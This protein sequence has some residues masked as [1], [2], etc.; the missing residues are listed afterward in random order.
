MLES[1]VDSLQRVPLQEGK[2]SGQDII[3]HNKHNVQAIIALDAGSNLHLLLTPTKEKESKL[4]TIKLKG[5]SINEVEWIVTGREN[6]VYIDISCKTG[7]LLGFKRPFL[8]FAEDV[9]L[10]ISENE[11]LPSESIYKTCLRWKKFWSPNT[12]KMVTSEWIH[13]IF[14]ELIFLIE[15]LERFGVNTIKSWTG[16]LGRDH[17]FQSS[18]D[19]A[20]EI[21]TSLSIPFKIN[22]NLKQLDTSLFKQLYII[23]YHI[24]ELD[25]GSTLPDLIRHIERLIGDNEIILE[26]FYELLMSSG[27]ELQLESL[28]NEHKFLYSPGAVYLVDNNFPKIVETSFVNPPDHRI[29]GIRYTVELTGIKEESIDSVT[30]ELMILGR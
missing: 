9:L 5:L 1:L 24:T 25:E 13:G 29:S 30:E 2:L 14:G 23:C 15:L 4:S 20:V 12:S 27:Y 11:D 3:I 7:S 6:Q 10:E 16:P 8:H 22:C 26:K 19:L 18:N 21:K 17:D 28:Y